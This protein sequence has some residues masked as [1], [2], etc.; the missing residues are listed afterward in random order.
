MQQ[1]RLNT[2]GVKPMALPE[3]PSEKSREEH[4]LCITNGQGAMFFLLFSPA[5]SALARIQKIKYIEANTKENGRGESVEVGIEESL[6]RGRV[7]EGEQ[8]KG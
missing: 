1:D 2:N 8:I 4:I 3:L 5:F 6:E 7:R